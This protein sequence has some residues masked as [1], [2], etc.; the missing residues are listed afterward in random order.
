MNCHRYQPVEIENN[1][2]NYFLMGDR[3]IDVDKQICS[4]GMFNRSV[5][6]KCDQD[7]LIYRTD[8]IT[9]VNEV[10]YL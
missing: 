6:I 3:F 7:G 8:E 5:I 4:K 10:N 2:S 1:T 9:I